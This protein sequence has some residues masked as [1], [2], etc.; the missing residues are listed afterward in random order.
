MFRLGICSKS[1]CLVICCASY[2]ICG[3]NLVFGLETFGLGHSVYKCLFRSFLAPSSHLFFVTFLCLSL[4]DFCG[5]L[6]NRQLVTAEQ[7]GTFRKI[8]KSLI[9]MIVG[10]MI[11]GTYNW[12]HGMTYDFILGYKIGDHMQKHW[13]CSAAL[14][15]SLQ[16]KYLNMAY[17]FCQMVM[18]AI[19]LNFNTNR[20]MK[21][22]KESTLGGR[23]I[24]IKYYNRLGMIF[25][26]CF[27]VHIVS[28]IFLPTCEENGKCPS[29]M[30]FRW[31]HDYSPC[32][33]LLFIVLGSLP[34][35]GHEL[36]FSYAQNRKIDNSEKKSSKLSRS[37]PKKRPALSSNPK[38]IEALEWGARTKAGIERIE[39]DK[40]LTEHIR[41]DDPF[42][43]DENDILTR[44]VGS[45]K[46]RRRSLQV[47][48]SSS[49]RRFRKFHNDMRESLSNRYSAYSNNNIL[50]TKSNRSSGVESGRGDNLPSLASNVDYKKNGDLNNIIL[51]SN[52]P[53]LVA[54]NGDPTSSYNSK[55]AYP[56]N[57]SPFVSPILS[58]F[59]R[60]GRKVS[61]NSN[62]TGI[63]NNSINGPN[64]NNNEN[65]NGTSNRNLN[66]IKNSSSSSSSFYNR[67]SSNSSGVGTRSF[68]N[69]YIS[70]SLV[71]PKA[72]DKSNS[73]QSQLKQQ[74][75]Q[76]QQPSDED[77]KDSSNVSGR[78]NSHVSQFI[79]S[80]ENNIRVSSQRSPEIIIRVNS[81]IASEQLPSNI[82]PLI[83]P[84]TRD[85]NRI[86]SD[87]SHMRFLSMGYDSN[88]NNN[89]KSRSR[90]SSDQGYGANRIKNNNGVDKSRVSSDQGHNANRIK[91][92]NGVDKRY[93]R[94][95]SDQGPSTLLSR[96][97]AI[98]NDNNE[99]FKTSAA[100]V[101]NNGLSKRGPSR[102]RCSSFDVDILS[103][104]SEMRDTID[105]MA[106]Q[107]IRKAKKVAQNSSKMKVEPQE[108]KEESSSVETANK[109]D[110]QT[111]KRQAHN[112]FFASLG[113]GN[114]SRKNEKDGKNYKLL[115]RKMSKRVSD[116][117]I[118]G[119]Y[120]NKEPTGK[121]SNLD[122]ASFDEEGLEQLLKRTMN[123]SSN[124]AE[125]KCPKPAKDDE[126]FVERMDQISQQ[127]LG[128]SNNFDD[129]IIGNMANEITSASVAANDFGM[130]F[131]ALRSISQAEPMD[132][133]TSW[134]GSLESFQDELFS[135][136]KTAIEAI[137]VFLRVSGSVL[138]QR[139]RSQD[140]LVV[141]LTRLLHEKMDE[142]E[143]L[144]V[145]ASRVKKQ[146]L[147]NKYR[148]R[149]ENVETITL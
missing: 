42:L 80:N 60:G 4:Y 92:N 135:R 28:L 139:F 97:P 32:Q 116:S 9:V 47:L 41:L 123:E 54:R 40:A 67:I 73:P 149:P 30:S 63:T 141:K 111:D 96:M 101:N 106:S 84:R 71:I 33:D 119:G 99:K 13:M 121:A 50:C 100:L 22:L 131:G 103:R 128:M 98:R 55:V 85:E 78:T 145:R 58:P 44:T 142:Y 53:P 147:K 38:E 56:K 129:K 37:N 64:N 76:Q 6:L 136:D 93:S 15:F 49:S 23:L 72:K 3:V 114:N 86:A 66:F 109:S 110:Q 102:L 65:P 16:T 91:N 95:S 81:R 88:R 52:K 45:T 8:M 5:I 89:D 39:I 43:N 144:A 132:L 79:L 130:E 31:I 19:Y 137:A 82:P 83:L 115:K 143:V 34:S 70:P 134:W 11:G 29:S 18:L 107:M 74:Q 21:G 126:S 25:F 61:S 77:S 124:S 105:D 35:I 24:H 14:D 27:A 36:F 57:K 90:V 113:F 140:R 104:D 26:L 138:Q 133:V 62:G 125:K 1:D 146:S 20:V 51:P 118:S 46:S 108:K 112:N 7:S 122:S 117:I 87:Q 120:W 94:V 2:V 127:F 68:N 69:K 148:V 10:L 48:S 17:A 75:Q 12:I 59:N